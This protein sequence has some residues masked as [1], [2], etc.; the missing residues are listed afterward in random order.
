MN[1]L[2]QKFAAEHWHFPNRD[3]VE[4]AEELQHFE[5]AIYEMEEELEVVHDEREELEKINEELNRV[6]FELQEADR[7]KQKIISKYQ[8]QNKKRIVY[9][10][11]PFAPADRIKLQPHTST[12]STTSNPEIQRLNVAITHQ[13]ASYRQ[14]SHASNPNNPFGDDDTDESDWENVS[15]TDSM[16]QD[17][18]DRFELVATNRREFKQSL[19]HLEKQL[20]LENGLEALALD[21]DEIDKLKSS[22]YNKQVRMPFLIARYHEWL[23]EMQII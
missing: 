15:E 3:A 20:H 2:S 23:C 7:K 18:D 17:D 19:A 21:Q 9:N 10:K 5:D 12:R 16:D 4:L 14:Y 11:K 6:V 13:P 1:L 8:E 22:H